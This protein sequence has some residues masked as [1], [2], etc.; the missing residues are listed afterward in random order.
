M[1]QRLASHLISG[2]H[3]RRDDFEAFFEDR[4]ERFCAMI[5]EAMGKEVHRDIQLRTALEDSSKFADEAPEDRGVAETVE[6]S[7]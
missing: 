7:V 3:L 5:G 6:A 4:R 2:A 1:D